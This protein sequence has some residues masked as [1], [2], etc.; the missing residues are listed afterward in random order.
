MSCTD[1]EQRQ[2]E[3]SMGV[4][5]PAR[6]KLKLPLLKQEEKDLVRE[7]LEALANA[8]EN[9]EADPEPPSAPKVHERP[10]WEFE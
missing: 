8:M 5:L 10:L 9:T 7:D 2:F 1:I 6:K 3:E 4:D